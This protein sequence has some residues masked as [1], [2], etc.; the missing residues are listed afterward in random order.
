ME[1]P[2]WWAIWNTNHIQISN[3]ARRLQAPEENVGTSDTP[4]KIHKFIP[5]NACGNFI[6]L[7]DT[8]F[9]DK[10]DKIAYSIVMYFDHLL[11]FT[12]ATIECRCSSSKQVEIHAILR[13]VRKAIN[14]KFSKGNFCTLFKNILNVSSNFNTSKFSLHLLKPQWAVHYFA[15]FNL[16]D[17]NVLSGLGPSLVSGCIWIFI[18]RVGLLHYIVVFVFWLF[19]IF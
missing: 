7:Y 5:H 13:E 2:L 19:I 11:I 1:L 4:L 14:L 10:E 8:N 6:I 12:S 15:K 3:H 9:S 17:G 16:E 18:V